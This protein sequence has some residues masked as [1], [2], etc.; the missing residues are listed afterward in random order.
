MSAS[1]STM[2]SRTSSMNSRTEP[3]TPVAES[4]ADAARP[5]GVKARAFFVTARTTRAPTARPIPSHSIRFTAL[6]LCYFWVV[7]EL[8]ALGAAAFLHLPAHVGL[9]VGPPP[10]GRRLTHAVA[11]RG[12]LD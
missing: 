5:C 4:R 7:R 3:S 1:R 2:P 9:V 12:R 6:P 11:E 8:S 10:V